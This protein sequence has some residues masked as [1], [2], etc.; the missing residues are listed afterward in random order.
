M[1][2]RFRESQRHERLLR[3]IEAQIADFARLSDRQWFSLLEGIDRLPP[4]EQDRMD[5]LLDEQIARDLALTPEEKRYTDAVAERIVTILTGW[6]APLV[7]RDGPEFERLPLEEQ[8]RHL[9]GALRMVTVLAEPEWDRAGIPL[10]YA[11][12]GWVAI[13]LGGMLPNALTLDTRGLGLCVC[14]CWIAVGLTIVAAW[15]SLDRARARYHEG[16]RRLG[17]PEYDREEIEASVA[18]VVC[19]AQQVLAH[20]AEGAD[21]ADSRRV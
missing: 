3:D 7:D 6:E 14:L 17:G 8:Q 4:D 11:C 9:V 5:G 21:K 10:V 19:E 2:D 15:V 16:Y 12:I 13:T 18:R 1:A 20:V